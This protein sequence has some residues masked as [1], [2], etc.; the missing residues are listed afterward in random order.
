[1]FKHGWW[2][3]WGCSA[4]EMLIVL[5]VVVGGYCLVSTVEYQDAL[6]AEQLRTVR[7]K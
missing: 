2:N 6:K 1:M 5:V 3:K 7:Y 4:V